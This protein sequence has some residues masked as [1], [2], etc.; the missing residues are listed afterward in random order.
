MRSE[1]HRPRARSAAPIMLHHYVRAEC[2]S[3]GWKGTLAGTDDFAR[4][5]G[6][7]HSCLDLATEL[8]I[9]PA[10]VDGVSIDLARRDG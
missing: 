4:E 10:D 2:N 1:V 9:G 5:E 8:P 6:R 3:C 7:K